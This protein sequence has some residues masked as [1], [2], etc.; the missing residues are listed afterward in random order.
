MFRREYQKK[1]RDNA[2]TPVQWDSSKNAGFTSAE[3]PWM[4]VNPNYAVINAAAQVDDPNSVFN[5]WRSVLDARKKYKDILVYGRFD[6]VDE[7][8]EKI[9]AYSRTSPEGRVLVVC[10]FSAEK[11]EWAG[12]TAAVQEVVATTTG[13]S[14][15]SFQR[16]NVLQLEPF[17][18]IALLVT[19]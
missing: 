18:A 9:F 1:S 17:E 8:N 19:E 3:K 10:N 6:L 5:C 14:R 2:R 11:I 4:T 13:R 7:K 15:Q 12:I 16:L